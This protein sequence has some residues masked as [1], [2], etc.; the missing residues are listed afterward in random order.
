MSHDIG[1]VVNWR[2]QEVRI[3]QRELSPVGVRNV[4]VSPKTETQAFIEQH[5]GLVEVLEWPSLCVLLDARCPA[6]SI[7]II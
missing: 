1:A 7:N 5:N 3:W 2:D 4:P 6:S